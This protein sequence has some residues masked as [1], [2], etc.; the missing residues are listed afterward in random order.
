MYLN[1]AVPESGL[2]QAVLIH[3]GAQAL[4]AEGA[5]TLQGLLVQ[6]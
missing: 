4:Q 1:A 5:Q 6:H 3:E 2:L